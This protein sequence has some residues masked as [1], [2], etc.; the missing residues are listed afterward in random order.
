MGVRTVMVT[1]VFSVM[2]L[3]ALTGC[4]GSGGGSFGQANAADGPAASVADSSPADGSPAENSTTE[5]STTESVFAEASV[6]SGP[7]GLDAMSSDSLTQVIG[8]NKER[9]R[10]HVACTERKVSQLNPSGTD[11]VKGSLAMVDAFIGCGMMADVVTAAYPEP[12]TDHE[13]ECITSLA[14]SDDTMRNNLAA[15]MRGQD[16][17]RNDEAF[18]QWAITATAKCHEAS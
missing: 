18:R 17:Q 9:T 5:N 6:S 1:C 2:G 7:V 8:G 16:A 12:A 15:A 11:D 13:L 10:R 3:A 4:N 14:M